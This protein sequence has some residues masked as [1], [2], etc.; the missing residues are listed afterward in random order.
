VAHIL[1]DRL[2]YDRPV[3][4][5]FDSV[6]RTTRRNR[7]L[8]TDDEVLQIL[9]DAGIDRKCAISVDRD[10]INDALDVTEPYRKSGGARDYI[11]YPPD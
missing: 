6:Q 2:H 3:H 8:K 4:G 9:E 11:D 5:K 10:K 1:L 7:Q